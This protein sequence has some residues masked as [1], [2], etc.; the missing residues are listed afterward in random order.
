MRPIEG[1]KR[2]LTKNR[3]RFSVSL[4][5]ASTGSQFYF[6][7]QIGGKDLKP[8]WSVL[9]KRFKSF[10]RLRLQKL[11]SDLT[12]LRKYNNENIVDYIT[13]AE[14][15]QLNISKVDESI[16]EKM[17][18]SMLLKG[19]P[20]ENESFCT[21]VKYS[22]DKPLDGIKLDLINFESERRNCRN[23]EKSE[24]IFFTNDRTC[25]N[26]HKRGILQNFVVHNNGNLTK[27]NLIQI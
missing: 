20:R 12:N 15:M 23:T 5:S 3:R 2:F 22:Q 14:D 18:V 21:L 17:F 10:E 27:R 8:G 25:F 1:E 11:I 9:C 26:C 24:S 6:H 13:R 7:D 19:V 4:F 16:S